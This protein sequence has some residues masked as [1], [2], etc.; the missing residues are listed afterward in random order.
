[1]REGSRRLR[2]YTGAAA[3]TTA[4]LLVFALGGG[5]APAP[6]AL[7]GAPNVVVIMTD[8][9]D[10][11]TMRAMPA[12]RRLIGG[13]G[14]TFTRSFATTP[15]CCPSRATFLTGQYAHNHG[16]RTN[17]PGYTALDASE[18]VAV[19]L[20]RAGY[21]TG[22]VGKF[23]NGYGRDTDSRE[24]PGGWDEWYAFV[25]DSNF[26][27]YDYTLNENGRLVRYGSAP[28]HYQTD[29]YARK[30]ADFVARNAGAE[31]F[32]LSVAT[33]A[34]H[35]EAH[36][37]PRPAPRHAGSFGDAPLPRPASF[38]ERNVGDKPAFVRK[39]PRLTPERIEGLTRLH[40]GR[41]RSLLAVD[42]LVERVVAALRDTGELQHTL[43]VFTSDNGYLLGQHRLV[44]K[45]WVY[46]SSVRVPLMMRGPG[47]PPGVVRRQLVGNV[48]LAPTIL[49]AAGASAPAAH[50]LDGTSLLAPA[51]NPGALAGRQ[52]LL[53]SFDVPYRA[54]RTPRYLFVRHRSGER[55]LYDLSRDPDELRSLHTSRAHEGV[56]RD[57]AARLRRL[58]GCAGSACV[59]GSG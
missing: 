46:E 14:A 4:T 15:L 23:L 11:G 57:L 35:K 26:S 2:A 28:R 40:R 12:V 42:D 53:E 22:H 20:D 3:A 33:L 21:R 50:R 34:P 30:A 16:V 56:E 31:P 1:M 48:D 8:D 39:T 37:P 49:D 29:V 10:P 18:T 32:F 27:Y 59:A 54:L 7:P 51:R 36:G 43:L 45:S 41:L 9:Q 55:E 5:V 44:G 38:N 19:W 6:G 25:H 52:L 17:K 58:E 24:I 13:Q 47:I